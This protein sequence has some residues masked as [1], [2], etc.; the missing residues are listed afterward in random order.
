MEENSLNSL[1]NIHGI[2]NGY[3]TEIKQKKSIVF[4]I[5]IFFSTNPTH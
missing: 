3:V 4:F 5:S 2:K 1:R